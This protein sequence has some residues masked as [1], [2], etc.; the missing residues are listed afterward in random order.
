ML[1]LFL[2]SDAARCRIGLHSWYGR[3]GHTGNGQ[4]TCG[5]VYNTPSLE[6][7]WLYTDWRGTKYRRERHCLECDRREYLKHHHEW[8]VIPGYEG[9][10]D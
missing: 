2:F 4:L 5:T 10:I 3:Y 6:G 7:E 9:K 1:F 8:I